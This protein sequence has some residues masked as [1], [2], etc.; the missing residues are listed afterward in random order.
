VR[1]LVAD[2]DALAGMGGEALGDC[3]A[4]KAGADDE[5]IEHGDCL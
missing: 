2:Q 1:T 4:G 5:V 3:G